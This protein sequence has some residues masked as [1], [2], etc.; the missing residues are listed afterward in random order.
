[1][2]STPP[3][4]G[5]RPEPLVEVRRTACP[6]DC[7]DGCSLEVTVTDGV[8][9]RVDAAP[10]SPVGHDG[11]GGANAVNPFM[12]GF[13]CAKV[14][15][16]ADRV[17]GP[18]RLRTPLMRTGPKGRGELREVSWDEAL[19]CAAEAIATAVDRHGPASVV[20]YLYNSSAGEL[21]AGLLGPLLGEALGTSTVAHTICAATAGAAWDLVLGNRPGTDLATVVDADLVVIW[22]ANPSVSNTH[23][24]PLV[25]QAC[26][27]GAA[28]VVVD[29]RRTP[30]AARA[31]VHLAVRP[32]ADVAVALAL[33]HAVA[34]RQGVH[35]DTD[36][37]DRAGG[38]PVTGLAPLLDA[39]AGWSLDAAGARAD[40]EP[41]ALARVAELLAG[42]ERPFVRLGWGLER[43]RNG[44][45]AHRA[46]LSLAVLAGAL[47]AEGAGG[48]IHVHTGH[49]AALDLDA[50]RL[51]VL[52]RP[53]ADD[54]L[55]RAAPGPVR[56]MNHLGRWLTGEPGEPHTAVL[57]VQ[58]ANPAVTAPAQ[59]RVLQGLAR[60]DLVT[61]VHDQVLTDTARFADIVLPATT[62]FETTDLLA[63]YGAFWLEAIEPVIPRV[64]RSRT[65]DEVT[66]GL[67]AHLGFPAERFDPR[68]AVVLARAGAAGG[69]A[70]R[71]GPAHPIRPDSD[72]R[73]PVH[74]AVDP[75]RHP[76]IDPVPQDTDPH[77]DTDTDTDAAS[78]R[79][80][81]GPLVLL[82]P[83]SSRTI[84]SMFGERDGGPDEVRLHPT[85]AAARGIRAGD[86]VRVANHQATVDAVAAVDD[87]TRPGVVVMVKGRWLRDGAPGVNALVPDDLADLAGG[88]T[89]NDARVEVTRA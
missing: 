50:L 25:R 57:F 32:G 71:T 67:A 65:N 14:R 20:P 68:P 24:P 29:P 8:L 62:H 44:G 2:P 86:A 70:H 38:A 72:A 30:L 47:G 63:P 33:I 89:F 43:N 61:I 51:A 48:G 13:I 16:H 6:L 54:D 73:S 52:G 85:D 23:L 36:L 18:H 83:A 9:T 37:R 19:G 27:A 4:T 53:G 21:S 76:G 40:V 88:A 59:A 41:A 60:D 35:G 74:L 45:A 10:P 17:H 56:N 79:D 75:A 22:G 31:D 28:L 34:E 58:G 1:M 42:A 78:V 64:G 3:P 81:E 15:R 84:N 7:P 77:P 11:D 69:H 26:D 66:A 55:R 87:R 46:V 82:S 5:P 80:G 49:D 39:A 12:Q